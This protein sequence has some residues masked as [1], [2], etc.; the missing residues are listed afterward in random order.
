MAAGVQVVWQTGPAFI[1]R[2]Q[3]AVSDAGATLVK[4]FDFIYAM[5]K[6]YAVADV[7]VS[8]AGALSVSELCLVEKP[9]ILVPFPAAAE[10]HQTKNA[11][12][13]V[14]RK[15]ALLIDDSMARTEL[16]AAALKLLSDKAQQTTLSQNIR[17][18]AKPTAAYDIATQVVALAGMGTKN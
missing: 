2:A 8:R 4:P 6:A 15:A 5:D 17:L 13:L 1:E 18:L 9:A 10:D 7:V 12:S 14:G 3:K 11:M 16:V